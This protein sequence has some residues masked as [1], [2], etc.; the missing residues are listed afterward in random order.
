MRSRRRVVRVARAAV[1]ECDGAYNH[2]PRGCT[3][4]VR[5]EG[6]GDN[7]R[8][9]IYSWRTCSTSSSQSTGTCDSRE[10]ANQLAESPPPP[11]GSL[12]H[13]YQIIQRVRLGIPINRIC[14]RSW[15]KFWF[16]RYRKLGD[17]NLSLSLPPQR[18]AGSIPEGDTKFYSVRFQGTLPW[19]IG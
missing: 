6:G 9:V 16:G 3:G 14:Y 11:H 17:D 13:R 10:W 1:R 19:R 8:H 15:Y 7:G 5:C 18:R 4:A 2:H 12:H